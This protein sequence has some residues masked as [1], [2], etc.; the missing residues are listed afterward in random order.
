[1]GAC[2]CRC[3][4]SGP[5]PLLLQP[6]RGPTPP[7]TT[8]SQKQ[9]P[10]HHVRE[11]AAPVQGRVRVDVRP[12]AVR[13]PVD[14]RGDRR[15]LGDEGEGVLEDGVPVLGLVEGAGLVLLGK[16][17]VG[18]C[19]CGC[20][21]LGWGAMGL[22]SGSKGSRTAPATASHAPAPLPP[23]PHRRARAAPLPP[24]AARGCRSPAASWGGCRAAAPPARA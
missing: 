24:P 6:T 2:R 9:A 12:A 16:L 1:M 21:G 3:C 13:A 18:L 8:P 15:Q 22:E 17:A 19:G 11:V 14:E 7:P 5:T 20:V 10:T 23:R 4:R